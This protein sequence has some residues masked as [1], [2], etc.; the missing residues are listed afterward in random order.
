M[1]YVCFDYLNVLLFFGEY[2]FIYLCDVVKVV[3]YL[4]YEKIGVGNDFLGW[5]DFFM[6]YD[7]EEFVCI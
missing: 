5:V 3:Y 4:I 2:E 7:K 1:I 6:E